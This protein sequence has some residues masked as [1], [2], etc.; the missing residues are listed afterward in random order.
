MSKYS[1]P[2]TF[3]S[4][5][6]Y[7]TSVVDMIS[8]EHKD[9]NSHWLRAIEQVYNSYLLNNRFDEQK[10]SFESNPNVGLSRPEYSESILAQCKTLED[11]SPMPSLSKDG[12]VSFEASNSARVPSVRTYSSSS[13]D[14]VVDLSTVT[15]DSPDSYRRQPPSR[16]LDC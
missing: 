5:K 11:H 15:I 10:K 12:T 16:R 8:M 2:T 7:L 1:Y 3:V 9:N 6:T 13:E 14:T 4:S